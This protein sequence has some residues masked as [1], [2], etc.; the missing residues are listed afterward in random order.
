MTATSDVS[1]KKAMNV[2][3]RAG[4]L[5]RSALRQD[6]RRAV[7]PHQR[8]EKEAARTQEDAREERQCVARTRQRLRHGIPE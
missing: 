5:R 4:M 1:L 7:V 2:L 3:T 8:R 6:H